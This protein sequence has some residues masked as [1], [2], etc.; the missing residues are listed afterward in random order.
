MSGADSADS[1]Q[2]YEEFIKAWRAF[3]P[4]SEDGFR[5]T[6]TRLLETVHL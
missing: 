3:L 6:V 2:A 1:V 4:L 5:I